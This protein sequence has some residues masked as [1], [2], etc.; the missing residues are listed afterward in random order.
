MRILYSNATKNSHLVRLCVNSSKLKSYILANGR[1]FLDF[2]AHRAV[3]VDANKE[4][5]RCLNCQR[6][7]HSRQFCKAK[8]PV[9]G[10]WSGGHKTDSY[11]VPKASHVQIV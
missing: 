1:N 6:Y 3:D 7:G 9:C 10:I 8:S 11:T 4:V 5:I 2:R